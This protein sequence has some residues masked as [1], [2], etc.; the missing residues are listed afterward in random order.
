MTNLPLARGDFNR[1][2]ART[3]SIALKNRYF[4]TNPVENDTGASAISRPRLKKAFE[5][6]DGPIRKVFSEPGAF[7]DDVFVLSGAALYA[8]DVIGASTLIGSTGSA[9]IS[10]VDMAVVA[11]IGGT[12]ERLFIADSGVLWAYAANG[13]AIGHLEASGAPANN[14]TVTIASTVY[15][16]TTG[17]VDAGS[18]AGTALNPWLVLSTGVTATDLEALFHAINASG[19]AGTEYSTALTAH[20]TVEAYNYTSTDL[21]VAARTAGTGGNT[22]ATTESSANLA[23]TAATLQSGGSA[24]LR[25]VP[26]PE[27]YTVSS[28]G[29][30]NSYVIVAVEAGQG[31]NGQF[32]W[33]EPGEI[34]ID[35][36]NFATAERSP[37]AI[38]QVI[39][40]SD[41]VWL[42][43]QR[44]AEPW[45][46][47]GDPAAPLQRFQGILY[48][49]GC[50]EGSACQVKDSL[51][52]CDQDGAVFQIGGGLKRISR[53]DIEER[54]RSAI[55]AQGS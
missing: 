17:S 28:I 43:G 54:I 40:F 42:L 5:V 30:I 25:Q 52:L 53:P 3:P 39:V 37:D 48:D 46:T 8:I 2:V 18:P 10:A 22:I 11:P 38:N 44:T 49:R 29:C 33:I 7:D 32:Y 12:P 24:L 27:D 34:T 14:D 55:Q 26:L 23:W 1:Q 47:T 6:G 9:E 19:T 35:P 50:W 51:I 31:V 16:F 21:Y 36:L 15:K 45:I 13:Q 4:E 20:A 41:M